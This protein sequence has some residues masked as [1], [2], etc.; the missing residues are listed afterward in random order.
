MKY[1]LILAA[2]LVVGLA[3]EGCTTV[4]DVDLVP[5]TTQL[6]VDG[7]LTD[8][9]GVQTIRLTQTSAYFDSSTP[10]AASNA[11]VTVTDD[12]GH[13]YSFTDPDGDSYYTWT[14]AG[15]DPLGVVGR[16]YT[17]SIQYQGQRYQATSHMNRV[18]TVD[19][20]IFHK[21]KRTVTSQEQGYQA[22]FFARDFAGAPDYYRVRYYR[23]G[24]LANKPADM[25][26]LY[27]ASQN[28]SFNSDGLSFIQFIRQRINPEKLYDEQDEVTVEIG[29]VTAD[30][31]D[32]LN[33]LETQVT[34]G[35]L[36]ATPPANVPTNIINQ[37]SG[38]TTA[39]GF[40]VASAIQRRSALALPENLR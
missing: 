3:L 9:A 16:S 38:G 10:P 21:E 23:N 22:E 32:F 8:Q 20:I 33:Q 40:F 34:N 27:D 39:T 17:L 13:T 4:I 15:K 14:P 11:T 1:F 6:S 26:Q 31:F 2:A 18:P 24:V 37:Q 12:Q 25:I 36:F 30:A 7:W 35:G 29:S 28:S 19:S 5:G